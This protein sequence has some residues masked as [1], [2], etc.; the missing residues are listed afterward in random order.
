M[1]DRSSSTVAMCLPPQS[2][3]E[4]SGGSGC[5][6]L[7][8]W[9]ATGV[10][11]FAPPKPF[12]HDPQAEANYKAQTFGVSLIANTLFALVVAGHVVLFS[13]QRNGFQSLPTQMYVIFVVVLQIFGVLMIK[14]RSEAPM[15][16]AVFLSLSTSLSVLHQ[17]LYSVDAENPS[18]AL[19]SRQSGSM[20][21]S[22][23]SC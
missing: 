21:A 4:S 1:V 22:F 23:R 12:Y 13:L 2:S 20:L 16:D 5:A 15:V 14:V 10:K 6:R 19:F 3:G 18:P 9:I 11:S 17:Y 7:I 8:S